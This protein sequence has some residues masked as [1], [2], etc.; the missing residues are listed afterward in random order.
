MRSTPSRL[1]K[2]KD[3]DVGRLKSPVPTKTIELSEKNNNDRA[4][5]IDLSDVESVIH[6]M[7]LTVPKWRKYLNSDDN[8]IIQSDSATI[9]PS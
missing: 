4:E 6:T 3:S 7:K 2:K 9:T 1:N 5:I 8:C